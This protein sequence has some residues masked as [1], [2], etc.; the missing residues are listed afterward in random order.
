MKKLVSIVYLA[1]MFIAIFYSK[2]SKAAK[3]VEINFT[4]NLLAPNNI[5]IDKI[6]TL[7][8][9]RELLPI[10]QNAKSDTLFDYLYRK[11]RFTCL[12][13]QYNGNSLYLT[14]TNQFFDFIGSHFRNKGTGTVKSLLMMFAVKK[15]VAESDTIVFIGMAKTKND[16]INYTS[17]ICSAFLSSGID[18]TRLI[19]SSVI[20]TEF[21]FDYPIEF[22]NEFAVF[23]QTANSSPSHSIPFFRNDTIVVLANYPGDAKGDKTTAVLLNLDGNLQHYYLD[24]LGFQTPEGKS[25][26]IDLMIFPII[27]K[28]NS[29]NED[30]SNLS[31]SFERIFP[32]PSNDI[33]NIEITNNTNHQAKI[34]IYDINGNKFGEKFIQNDICSFDI[35]EL[36]KGTYYITLVA[37]NERVASKFSK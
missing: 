32:I 11:T 30:A 1:M 3:P 27:D 26:D 15:I 22:Y 37:G 8:C 16:T 6:E 7:D 19:D 4:T 2:E 33:I 25:M 18:T 36:P 31:L 13:G 10:T 12:G 5:T 14:G 28:T 29:I 9:N 23:V 21:E 17:Q 34:S 20:M 24:D 35:S